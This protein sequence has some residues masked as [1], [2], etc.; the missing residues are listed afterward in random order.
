MVL[1]M[2]STD[3]QIRESNYETGHLNNA[4]P[5]YNDC[6]D[7]SIKSG[8]HSQYWL[9]VYLQSGLGVFHL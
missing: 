2:T 4:L 1:K 8:H 5:T 9:S 6:Y 3:E 7:N